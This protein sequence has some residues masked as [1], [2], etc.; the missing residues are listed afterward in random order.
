MEQDVQAHTV[1]PSGGNYA[2]KL[3][4][5]NP[6]IMIW[7]WVVFIALLVLL[8]KFAWKPILAAV[9]DRERKLKESLSKADEAVAN[10]AT[11]E[12]EQR[13]ILEQAR[14]EATRIISEQRDYAAKFKANSEADAK[15][16]AE[17]IVDQAKSEI[18]A[19]QQQARTELSRYAA[20][21]SVGVAE[22]ILRQKLD[23]PDQ[24]FAQQMVSEASKG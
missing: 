11:I 2:T 12:A 23:T 7:V 17:K 8:H 1:A 21:L 15:V 10:A 16:A 24:A 19:A 20:E 14:S 22:K 4:T 5:P 9:S 18:H 13:K 3:M 6:G